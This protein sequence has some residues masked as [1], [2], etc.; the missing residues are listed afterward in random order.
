M[1]TPLGPVRGTLRAL[2]NEPTTFHG[3]PVYRCRVQFESF[4]NG[5]ECIVKELAG[6]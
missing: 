2:F 1:A 5:S 3:S 6:V 4:D